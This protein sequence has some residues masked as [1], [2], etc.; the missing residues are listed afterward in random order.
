MSLFVSAASDVDPDNVA[1]QKTAEPTV[2]VKDA[3]RQTTQE[4]TEGQPT[5]VSAVETAEKDPAQ[6]R[7][8]ASTPTRDDEAVRKP[9]TSSVVEEGD[10]APTPPPAEERR[11]PTPP[12]AEASLLKGSP[13]RNKGPVIH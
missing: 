1:G 10:R 3:A 6:A 5:V 8:G 4:R 11:D 2:V 9:P 7:T 13:G 12:R